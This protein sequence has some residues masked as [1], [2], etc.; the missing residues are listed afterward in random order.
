LFV[1]LPI[2]RQP[3]VGRERGKLREG[4]ASRSHPRWRVVRCKP[5]PRCPIDGIALDLDVACP[6]PVHIPNL[7]LRAM[8]HARRPSRAKGRGDAAVYRDR[9]PSR[10]GARN[11]TFRKACSLS[12]AIRSG[13]R[14]AAIKGV[15]SILF[16]TST[17]PL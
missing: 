9:P 15:G 16:R 2:G 3:I 6:L 4:T 1:E 17:R 14:S 11:S 12:L 13:V 8:R 10:R 5:I 7:L